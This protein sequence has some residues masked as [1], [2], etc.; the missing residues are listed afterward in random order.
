VEEILRWTSATAYNRR[1]ATRD[2][3][4]GGVTI[5]AGEKTTHWYP[6]A[7]RDD[8]CS[9]IPTDST[10]A[11]TRTRTSPSATAS[12]TASG[13]RWRALELATMLDVLLDRCAGF[14]IAGPVEWGRSNKH[15]SIRHLPVR[16]LP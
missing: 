13:H 6:A 12:T 16:L 4:L 2:I 3:E 7:N 9:S 10:S 1:T 11:G 15:T 8:A 14:E 5:R